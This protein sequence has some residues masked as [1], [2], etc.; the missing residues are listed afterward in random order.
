MTNLNQ[1]PTGL[2]I[3]QDDGS[4]NHLKGMSLP[5]VSLIATNGQSIHFGDIKGKLVIYCYPMTGQPS[6]AL[7][8]GWDQ[9]PGARG[10]TPQSCSFRDHYQE[11]QALG[12]EVVGLSVQ[13]TEY[14]KEMAD[15]L[16]LPFPVVSDEGYQFQK[17]L[18]M[19]TFVAAGM[20]L[21]KRVT[22]IAN[23]GVIEAV[24]YPIFPSDSD[25][26]W[27]M[28]YLKSQQS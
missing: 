11:L 8:D 21:L 27:V 16:H 25:P 15:R 23:H 10:C 4:T 7:P 2:P 12:A 26:A 3:P 28:D 24:H 1:L 13:S 20:T 9:I 14:Q 17:A 18:N 22:L 6:V 5:N 19:P